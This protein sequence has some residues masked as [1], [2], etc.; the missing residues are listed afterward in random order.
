MENELLEPQPAHVP[1]KTVLASI[2]GLWLTYFLLVTVRSELLDLG[3]EQEMLWRRAVASLAGVA[4]VVGLWL[5]LRLFDARPLWVKIAAALLL[6][7]PVALMLAEANEMAFAPLELRVQSRKAAQEGLV[8]RR[9]AS[10]DLLVDVP[11]PTPAGTTRAVT[12]DRQSAWESLEEVAFGRYF[13]SL[14][15]CALYLAL[16]AGEKARVAERREGA[17]RRAAKAAE[18]RSLRYQV[19]PHFLFNTLN[20]LSAL[21]L[22]GKTAA[23]E[24]MIQT[25]STFYRRSLADDPTADV[26]LR[27]EF[28]LQRLYLDIETVRFPDRLKAEYE[29]PE[30]LAGALVP[31]MILQPIVENSVRHAVAPASRKV[32]ITLSAR[33]EYGRLVVTVADDGAGKGASRPGFG[34]GLGNVEERLT[35]RFGNEASVVS[36]PTST[37]YATHIRLPLIGEARHAA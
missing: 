29:L 6:S 16:L 21:V 10:G 7:I 12:I 35:A 11:I 25:I 19:N 24:R 31:G 36:G 37:G 30:A 27:E 26:P 17:F 20:S 13:M 23:A 33:E 34:I 4:I 9:D 28:A 22:T 2:V 32:T 15:W 18:L 8:V 3:F 1:F 5:V 14:A